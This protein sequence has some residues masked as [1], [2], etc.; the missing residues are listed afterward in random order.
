MVGLPASGRAPVDDVL[1]LDG[2]YLD[3]GDPSGVLVERHMADHFGLSTGDHLSVY[4][5]SGW[6]Q[7]TVRGIAASAEYI[8]PARSRQEV[9][10]LPD[11][12]GVIFAPQ[13]LVDA[14]PGQLTTPQVLVTYTGAAEDPALTDTL[15]ARAQQAGAASAFTR[16]DQPSNAALAE[17]INGFGELSLMFPIMFLTAAGL[18]TYVLLS[19]MVHAQRPQIGLLLAV[20]FPRRRVFTHYLGFGLITGLL[21]SGLGAVIG[22]LLAGVIT[23]VYTGVISIPVTIVEL[24]PLTVVLGIAF[25]AVAGALASL[26]PALRASRLSPAAAMSGQIA[27]GIGT[28]SL[29]ERLIP[30]LRRLPARWK[31]VVRGIGRSPVRSIS[32]VVGVMIAVTLVLV[33]WGMLDT[34]QVLVDRQF[35]QAQ[36]ADALVSLPGGVDASTLSAIGATS[37]VASVEPLT[38]LPVTI[39]H[40]GQ[41]YATELDAFPANTV[42]HRFLTPN[43]DQPLPTDGV[44][45][46]S[47]LRNTIGLAEGDQVTLIFDGLDR[48]VQTRVSGFVDEPLGTYAYAS[49]AVIQELIGA[50][51]ATA[52]T[53]ANIQFTASADRGATMRALESVTGVAAVVD[54]KGLKQAAD[55]LMG[56]FYVFVG[57]MLALGA[58]MAFAL[59]FNLMSANISERLTE[60]ASLRASGMSGSE[61]SRMIT[62]ENVL[63]TLAGIVPGLIVGYFGAAAFMAS[64]SSDLFQFDLQVRPTTFVFTAI[65]VLAAALISQLPI[66]RAVRRIDVARVVR[67]RAL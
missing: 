2:S 22:L 47:A 5:A 46:G 11:Q 50:D 28:E 56:L 65:G 30:P 19:R 16:A 25:G 36:Q 44:L 51:A 43:G 49:S 34:V 27:A 45:V 40:G 48:S 3:P 63:L 29:A 7:L 52:T 60:L 67:E 21:G 12:F 8:W 66:L 54:L 18:A 32:T 59:L 17:D 15:V 33:S 62:G 23:N 35:N 26:A 20:G 38:Q 55:A 14:L 61:L 53:A 39:D 58:V 24:R 9:L 64:F 10:T 13:P 6:E 57:V 42:M 4:G 37:G 31:M 41:R 1:I